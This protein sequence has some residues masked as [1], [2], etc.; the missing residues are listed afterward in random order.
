MSDKAVRKC[1]KCRKLRVRR[2]ISGGAG[3]IFKGSGFYETDYKRNRAAPDSAR[4]AKDAG[5][6]GTPNAP[7][8]GTGKDGGKTPS[9]GA[10]SGAAR[11]RDDVKG[12]KK[13]GGKD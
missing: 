7:A 6:G 3:V 2:L 12:G 10:D 4:K 5:D 11:A 9:A 13:P 1:P 8:A